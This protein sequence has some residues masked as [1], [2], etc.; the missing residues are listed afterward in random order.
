MEN[1]TVKSN[2]NPLETAMK[3]TFMIC[4]AVAIVAILLICIFIF[5]NGAPAI[6]EIG[7]GDF[8][9]GT[10]W[11]PSGEIFGILPMILG[12]LIVTTGALLIGVP[13]GLMTAIYLACFCPPKVYRILKPAVELLAGIPSVV[14]GFFGLMIIVPFIA[15]TLGGSG[16]SILAT[17]IILCMMVLPSIINISETSLRAVPNKYYEGALALGANKM[18]AVMK[19]VLPAAKSGVMTS[20][21]L[22]IGRAIGETM[23]VMLVSGNAAIMPQLWPLSGLGATLLSPVRTMTAGVALEM[24]YA[25]GLHRE[26]LMG[27][28]VVLFLFII[29]LNLILNFVVRK[30]E[31]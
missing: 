19:V 2:K 3:L 10:R 29:A 9:T 13:V 4:A 5:S 30:G 15:Q 21:I 27:I 23:A 6:F 12:S 25:A 26:A 31:K 14:F 8:L 20:I 1:T 11:A 7:V 16:F 17:I 24:G 18:E 22:G 28:G